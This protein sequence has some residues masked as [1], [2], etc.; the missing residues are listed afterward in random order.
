MPPTPN[1]AYRYTPST[2]S[3]KRVT[4][5]G[6][7]AA[8]VGQVIG[9]DETAGSRDID[10]QRYIGLADAVATP[11][12][13]GA[14]DITITLKAISTEF[15]AMCRDSYNSPAVR[16]IIVLVSEGINHLSDVVDVV[17]KTTT[18]TGYVSTE[19]AATSRA[20]GETEEYS[21]SLQL[22]AAPTVA[23]AGGV[24]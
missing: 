17:T 16:L 4:D 8:M 1:G 5:T 9:I 24:A 23:I 3:A 11:T 14:K 22:T 21:V 20:A 7:A 6:T 19:L 10:E 12:G 15:E 13:K 2:I 18:Y